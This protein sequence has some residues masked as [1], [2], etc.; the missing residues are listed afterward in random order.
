[1]WQE[2]RCRLLCEPTRIRHQVGELGKVSGECLS[3]SDATT[4][5]VDIPTLTD[6]ARIVA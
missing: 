3:R 2:V 4:A 1:M 5:F 6:H